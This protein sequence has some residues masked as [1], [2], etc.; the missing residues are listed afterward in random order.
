MVYINDERWYDTNIG[1]VMNHKLFGISSDVFD[2]AQL[3]VQI[4]ICLFWAGWKHGSWVAIASAT[5]ESMIL[6][7]NFMRKYIP[8]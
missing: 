5:I 3:C 2:D 1:V 7:M 4:L 6:Q 8:N